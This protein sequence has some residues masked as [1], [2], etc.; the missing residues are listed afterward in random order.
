MPGGVS[1]ALASVW[2]ENVSDGSWWY[3]KDN[4]LQMA[5]SIHSA[6]EPFV[7]LSRDLIEGHYRFCNEF[8][9]PVLHDLPEYASYSDEDRQHYDKFN[10]T[11]SRVIGHSQ[12]AQVDSTFFVQD[13]Q[14]ALMP[15][16]LRRVGAGGTMI[17]WHV[18]WPQHVR[19]DHA[20]ILTPIAKAMLGADVVGFHTA[21]YGEN[22]LSFVQAYLPDHRC[23]FENMTVSPTGD[24]VAAFVPS[25]SQGRQKVYYPVRNA[26]ANERSTE[27][28]VAPLGIDFDHWS[29]LASNP[30]TAIWQPSLA[31]I[32]YVLSV[33][34]VDYSKGVT[35]RIRAID[36]FLEKYPEWQ[37]KLV[38]AQ[39]CGRTRTGL[40]AYD[41]YWQE[42]RKLARQ[43]K[44][45][46]DTRHWQP[47]LWFERQFSPPRTFS[48]LSRCCRYVGQSD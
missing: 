22:F 30:K 16:L 37:G 31:K 36:A 13:Y 46:W 25:A 11:L 45:K 19:S 43:L 33:D 35:A 9:W 10:E 39:L 2:E 41:S 1:A 12:T 42:C 14:L 4:A 15:Q 40:P 26:K 34:R 17:F 5:S 8:L 27:I 29:S 44:E 32:P 3:V 7:S 18:P 28:V 23:D 6:I 21:E 48:A 20:R 24:I 47:L 38:F